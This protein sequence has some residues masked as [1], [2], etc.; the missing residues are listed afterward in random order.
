MEMSAPQFQPRTQGLAHCGWWRSS[1]QC[2]EIFCPVR[3]SPDSRTLKVNVPTGQR[4]VL[5]SVT[6]LLIGNILRISNISESRRWWKLDKKIRKPCFLKHFIIEVHHHC[7]N[8]HIPM[9]LLHHLLFLSYSI[10][11]YYSTILL[12]DSILSFAT[13]Q[14]NMVTFPFHSITQSQCVF[15]SFLHCSF[16]SFNVTHLSWV[17]ASVGTT[18]IILNAQP[19]LKGL[20]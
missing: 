19:G 4:F 14:Y 16:S 13:F 20:I 1:V 11:T 6:S 18:L 2:P 8:A 3:C 17:E 15:F 5:P 9:L 10:I 12:C 7:V